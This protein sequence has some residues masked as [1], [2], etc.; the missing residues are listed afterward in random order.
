MKIICPT[1]AN[2]THACYLFLAV[3]QPKRYTKLLFP[4]TSMNVSA[5]MQSG[6]RLLSISKSYAT[7]ISKNYNYM[8]Y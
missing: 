6:S 2:K 8:K 1:N 4:W 5:E 7:W 3:K